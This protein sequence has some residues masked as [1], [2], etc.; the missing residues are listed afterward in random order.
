M[1]GYMKYREKAP[2][3][4]GT[5]I[6]VLSPAGQDVCIIGNEFTHG[7]PED[8]LENI[9]ISICDGKDACL[10]EQQENLYQE[11]GD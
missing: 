7:F 10:E 11:N 8:L 3:W 4:H 6:H 2:P 1:I 9:R 5:G